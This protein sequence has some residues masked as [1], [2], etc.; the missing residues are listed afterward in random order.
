MRT[1]EYKRDVTGQWRKLD[2]ELHNLFS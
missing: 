1:F 2:E